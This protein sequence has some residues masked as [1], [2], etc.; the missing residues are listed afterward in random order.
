MSVKN[1]GTKTVVQGRLSYVHIFKPYAGIA[2]QEEK[3][4]TTILIPK[5][6]VAT[7]AASVMCR[8]CV[9]QAGFRKAFT[10]SILRNSP[11]I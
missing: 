10:G 2:G 3:Y 9:N 1:E 5:K 6:D 4:S 7:K 11:L 8:A